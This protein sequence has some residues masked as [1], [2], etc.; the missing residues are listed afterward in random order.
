MCNLFIAL[1][2]WVTLSLYNV[3][4]PIYIGVFSMFNLLFV[5]ETKNEKCSRM[6]FEKCR[7]FDETN[8]ALRPLDQTSGWGGCRVQPAFTR[9]RHREKWWEGTLGLRGPLIYTLNHVGFYLF[10]HVSLFHLHFP[11]FL[12]RSFLSTFLHLQTYYKSYINHL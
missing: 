5:S 3:F 9:Y 1:I 10:R 12:W 7:L 4:D 8:G 2:F 6:L 11:L